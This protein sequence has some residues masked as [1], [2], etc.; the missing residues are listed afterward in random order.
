[1]LRTNKK[2]NIKKN[3]IIYC[4]PDKIATLQKNGQSSM[5]RNNYYKNNNNINSHGVPLNWV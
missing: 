3:V 2:F 5:S 1:M 4:S